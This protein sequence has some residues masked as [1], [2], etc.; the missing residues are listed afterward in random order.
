M[1]KQVLI[2]QAGNLQTIERVS[3]PSSFKSANDDTKFPYK[4]VVVSKGKIK[5]FISLP[6]GEKNIFT[7]FQE[8][9]RLKIKRVEIGYLENNETTIAKNKSEIKSLIKEHLGYEVEVVQSELSKEFH[10]YS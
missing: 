3:G 2:G 4:E 7:E 6:I 8:F 5:P 9:P 10:N 1:I